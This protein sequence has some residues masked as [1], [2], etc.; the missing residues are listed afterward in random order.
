LVDAKIAI[1]KDYFTK[2]KKSKWITNIDSRKRVHLIRSK[3]DCIISSSKSINDDNSLLSCRIEGLEHKSPTI[4]IIDRN[5]T[6]KKN[7]KIFENKS[8][9][10]IILFTKKNNKNK[11]NFLRLKGVKIFKLD[12]MEN[13]ADYKRILLKISDLGYS[14]ILLESG[15]SLLNFFIKSKFIYNIFL[16]HSNVALKRNGFNYIDS[17]FLKKIKLRNK[18][19]VN[20]GNDCLYK[21]RIK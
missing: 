19:K 7:L 3:Y 12:K 6:I 14:R 1:S 9:R 10:K 8:K 21:M 17:S 16:F 11:E 13:K 4:I 5:L 18:I 15:L 20:L 2:N